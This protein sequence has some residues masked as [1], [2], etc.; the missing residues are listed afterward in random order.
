LYHVGYIDAQQADSDLTTIWNLQPELPDQ[1]GVAPEQ[2]LLICSYS[3][4]LDLPSP[5]AL[6]Q[7]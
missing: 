1:F 7:N 6:S 5:I 2:D 3:S 4:F